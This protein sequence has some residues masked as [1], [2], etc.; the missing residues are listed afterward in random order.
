[1]RSLAITF[2]VLLL[3]VL[4]SGSAA[5][6][7]VKDGVII[8]LP[9]R[10]LELYKKGNMIK[11]YPVGVGMSNFPT[12]T[13]SFEII[14]MVITPDWENPYK[15]KGQVQVKRGHSN[16][17]GT[18]WIG[19]KD[20]SGG[21]YGIH[22]TNRPSSVGK[23]SSHGCIR[24]KIKDAEELFNNVHFGMPVIITN[25]VHRLKEVKEIIPVEKIVVETIS[26][27]LILD[28]ADDIRFYIY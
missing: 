7:Q 21:Q 6:S 12:P 18:R 20:Y 16:P 13:G 28:S 5:F 3:L 2:L 1:M 19:F 17:L 8:R 23:Y 4:S 11:K 26:I 15:S 10:V 22:G 9:T 24:M 27:P 14:E 25:E